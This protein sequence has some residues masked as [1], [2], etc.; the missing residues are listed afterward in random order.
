ML[1]RMKTEPLL[2]SH[3][4]DW[5]RK[6]KFWRV[7]FFKSFY[8]CVFVGGGGGGPVTFFTF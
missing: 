4:M 8:M 5:R 1:V 7:F 3:P 6:G 2:K